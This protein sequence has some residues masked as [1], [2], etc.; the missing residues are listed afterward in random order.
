MPFG[1]FKSLIQKF[2]GKPVDWEELEEMLIRADLGVPMAMRILL[3]W[4]VFIPSSY[5]VVEV[6]GGGAIGAMVCVVGY[7]GLLGL[8]LAYR[9]RSGKWKSIELIEPKLV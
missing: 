3:A 7:I 2:T 9:F 8:L 1:F 6:W 4:V 5:L